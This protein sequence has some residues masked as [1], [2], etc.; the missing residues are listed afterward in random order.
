MTAPM[1]SLFNS[2]WP[3]AKPVF[4]QFMGF[5]VP[6]KDILRQLGSIVTRVLARL[7]NRRVFA[8]ALECG[9]TSPLSK[10]RRVCA[11]QIPPD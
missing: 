4:R 5:R 7:Q 3:R 9:D 2:S 11:L 10:R 1:L 6:G 8:L